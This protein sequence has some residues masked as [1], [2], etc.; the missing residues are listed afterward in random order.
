MAHEGPHPCY[1]IR[2]G[3]RGQAFASLAEHAIHGEH[4]LWRGQAGTSGQRPLPRD[5]VDENGGLSAGALQEHSKHFKEIGFGIVYLGRSL[6][7]KYGRPGSAAAEEIRRSR[8]SS[9]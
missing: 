2:D 7:S 3:W 8:L 5:D 9:Q 4:V 1:E 6:N